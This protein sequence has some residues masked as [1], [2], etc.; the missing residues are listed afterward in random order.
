[1]LKEK[2]EFLEIRAMTD[3]KLSWEE[4]SKQYNQQWVELV[5]YEWSDGEANPCGGVV[6]VHAAD[7]KTFYSLA[8]KSPRPENSAILFVGKAELPPGTV[9]CSS[10]MRIEHA[11][12]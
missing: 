8:N 11:N 1:M 6:R 5:D 7:R 2:R 4:I 12:S 9:L 3:Q 10:L